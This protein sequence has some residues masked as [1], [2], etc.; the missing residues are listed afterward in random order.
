M[1]PSVRLH[2]PETLRAASANSI[3]TPEVEFEQYKPAATTPQRI[4]DPFTLDLLIEGMKEDAY[5][6]AMQ[7]PRGSTLGPEETGRSYTEPSKI[8]YWGIAKTLLGTRKEAPMA[9]HCHYQENPYMFGDAMRDMRH[10]GYSLEVG[11]GAYAGSVAEETRMLVITEEGNLG[12]K[13]NHAHHSPY[14]GT[15][16]RSYV[17]REE[18]FAPEVL[19]GNRRALN[20]ARQQ[21][22]KLIAEKGFDPAFVPEISRQEALEKQRIAAER[23]Y[24]KWQAERVAEEARIQASWWLR[25]RRWLRGY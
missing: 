17:D 15:R 16:I 11:L 2:L 7:R 21:W 8:A 14:P 10:A 1:R 23:A 20:L 18:I 5:S 24:E 19:E 13:T 25:T 12:L 22:R 4:A 9:G 3:P 6:F